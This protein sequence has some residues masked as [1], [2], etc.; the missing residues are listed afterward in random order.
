MSE[1]V[2]LTVGQATVRFLAQ[3]YTERD[4]VE[5]KFFE[6]CFGIFGH[7]NVAGLGQALLEAEVSDPGA[8]VYRQARNEQGMVHASSA[9]ARMRNRLS[10]MACTAS[11]GPGATNMVTGA[12]LATINRLPVLLL[13]GDIFATRV[14]SPV[15]QELESPAGYDVSVNDVFRPVSRFFDRVW[16]PEQLPAALLGAMR[17]LTDPAETGAATVA[18]PQDVQAEAHDWP[19]ELFQRRVW[20]V[21]RPVPE[22]AALARAVEIIRSAERPMVVAGGGVIYSEATD[23]LREFCEATGIPVGE[24]QAGKGSLPYDHPLALGAVGSTGTT[25][26]NRIAREADVVI[27]IGTRYSD[28]TTASRTAFQHPGVRFVNINITGLDGAKHAGVPVVADARE[29]LVALTD[30]LTG[31][32]TGAEYRERASSL[33]AEW[34]RTVEAAYHL[35]HGPLPAQSEIIGAV[36]DVSR[37]RDVVICAAGS[38]PGDLHKLWRTRDPKGY[39]VEYGYSCMGYEI[40]GGLG[41]KMAALSADDDRDVY[42][43]VGDG[44]YLMMAQELVTAVQEGIKIIV[45]LVQN[46]GF[47]SIGALSEEVGVE[48]FGTKYRYRDAAT[49]RLDG[50]TLP[51]D[52]AA[53][54]ASLGVQVL[55]ASGVD[56][57]RAAL[58]Q[59]REATGPFMVHIDTDPMVPAPDSE[60]WWDVPVAEVAELDATRDARKTYDDHK[61]AQRPYL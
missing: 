9:F 31:Y 11:I 1:T 51:V 12:A 24:S 20:H 54:A 22:P 23:A 39:H 17:V 32:D 16:R 58:R 10:T 57:F 35:G 56:E 61:T 30:A 59:A 38:M 47:Q 29:A 2:R 36:N 18:I 60:S 43:M 52:L 3:Q 19:V 49:G 42:V 46:H 7:G 41:A 44:S 33:A 15:L 14:A 37:P 8:L 34:D 21:P 45:V 25:A 50:E 48:R 13:P 6:G 27:G 28:F 40:A 55:R 4:G 5:H 26:A 53:N